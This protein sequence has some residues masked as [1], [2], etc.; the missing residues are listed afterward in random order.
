[1][2]ANNVTVSAFENKSVYTTFVASA[3]GLANASDAFVQLRHNECYL[4]DGQF[5]SS[6]GVIVV[7]VLAYAYFYVSFSQ[8]LV[9]V[10]LRSTAIRTR[11]HEQQ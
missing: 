10:R 9:E 7:L 2:C 4:G 5:H 3:D 8:F 11:H 1:V 6:I